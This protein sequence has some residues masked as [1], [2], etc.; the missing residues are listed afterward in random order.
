MALNPDTLAFPAH[1][2]TGAALDTATLATRWRT[3]HRRLE[4]ALHDYRVLRGRAVPGDLAWIGAQLRVA[5]ARCRCHELAE[6]L[7]AL[8]A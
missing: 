3:A 7:E 2:L 8:T 1:R 4:E 6:E 5:Q